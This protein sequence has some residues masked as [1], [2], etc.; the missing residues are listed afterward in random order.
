[1]VGVRE[2][3]VHGVA[4][5]PEIAPPKVAHGAAVQAG[6][7]PVQKVVAGHAF[8]DLQGND[9][10]VKLHRVSDAVN[11]ADAGHDEDI[12]PSAEQGR[13]GG[14]PKFFNLVVDLKVLLDVRVRSGNER[15]GLV[16]IVVTDE[17]LDEVVGE[18]GLEFAVEL[19]GQGFVVAQDQCRSLGLGH[20]ICHRKGLARACHPKQHLVGC[21]LVDPLHQLA[22]RFGLVA[23]GFKFARELEGG[24]GAKVGAGRRGKP[25]RS[26]A[27][28][29]PQKKT[30]PEGEVFG[31]S[32]EGGPYSA[33]TSNFTV[34]TTSLWSLTVASY[35]P[36]S[37]MVSSAR[38]ICLRSTS[39]PAA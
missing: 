10:F 39:Y 28:E 24:H 1:M 29:H 37:L 4:F 21:P 18:K 32:G 25:T 9:V 17:V 26:T 11:A 15:F 27:Q 8:S 14:Q 34:T 20:H 38:E 33:T 6:H 5:D 22:N 12:T 23:G 36:N 13:G 3:H 7:Q 35:D 30:P 16:V 31:K 2:M 19:S